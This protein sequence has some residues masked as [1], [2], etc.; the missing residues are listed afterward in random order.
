MKTPLRVAPAILICLL[1]AWTSGCRREAGG[2][3]LTYKLTGTIVSLEP[4]NRIA[5]IQHEDILDSQGKVWMRA[6]TMDFPVKSPDDFAKLKPGLK[7]HA[8]VYQRTS[9]LEYWIGDV[10]PAGDK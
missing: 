3:V 10:E 7:I 9:D 4:K 8:M 5:V 2:P 1:A 6:M